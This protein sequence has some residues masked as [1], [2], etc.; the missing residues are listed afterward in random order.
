MIIFG[1]NSRTGEIEYCKI[2]VEIKDYIV[3]IDEQNC[4]DQPVKE[5]IIIFQ[6]LRQ[7]KEI[8]T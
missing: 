7:V 8:I 4:F 5:H 2:S 1:Y 3:M 6:R